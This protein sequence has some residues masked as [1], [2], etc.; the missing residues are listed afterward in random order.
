MSESVRV[1]VSSTP[2][3]AS[4]GTSTSP[5]SS[6]SVTL[7]LRSISVF[8]MLSEARTVTSYRLSPFRSAGFSK[9][10]SSLREST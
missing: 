6:A 2:I 5:A 10:G 9:S 3:N 7:M 8:N 4:C 1:A